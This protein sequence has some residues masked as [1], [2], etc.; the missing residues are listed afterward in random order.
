MTII[1]LPCLCDRA[2]AR[3]LIPDI[4]DALGPEPLTINAAAVERI[5]QAM[6]QVLVA[7]A[8]SDSG[9]TITAPSSA[10]E[11]ALALTGLD[12]VLGCEIGDAH[13]AAAP[14]ENAQ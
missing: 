1:T 8:R 11:E 12:R 9:I 10:F 7:A 13:T 4:R 3:A 6:L 2:A 14:A 5:G